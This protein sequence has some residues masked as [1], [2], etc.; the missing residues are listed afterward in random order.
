M[1]L[2][3][4]SK[5]PDVS[6]GEP[7]TAAAAKKD[8]TRGQPGRQ[9]LTCK[10]ETVAEK[11]PPIDDEAPK[12]I[13]MN[14]PQLKKERAKIRRPGRQL[15]VCASDIA[16]AV[17]APPLTAADIVKMG[18]AA[19]QQNQQIWR[20]IWKENSVKSLR[21][22]RQKGTDAKTEDADSD[23]EMAAAAAAKP[24]AVYEMT[25]SETE[26]RRRQSKDEM[27]AMAVAAKY[28]T[29]DKST[30][31]THPAN[32]KKLTTGLGESTKSAGGSGGNGMAEKQVVESSGAE[33]GAGGLESKVLPPVDAQPVA[34]LRKK[35][36][37]DDD[38]CVVVCIAT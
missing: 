33:G 26:L 3:G 8:K 30:T 11:P 21:S 17:E 2:F 19:R 27:I 4:R 24:V 7:A 5:Q 32:E 22:Q 16:A 20:E 25:K 1:L 6:V 12:V 9:P 38:S 29:K 18:A 28:H 34:V 14:Q 15:L 10:T 31:K 35:G 37:E 36:Q 23:D 13:I